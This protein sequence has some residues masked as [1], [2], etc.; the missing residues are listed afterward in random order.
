MNMGDAP[1]EHTCSAEI[2][3]QNLKILTVA[4]S[5][6]G[7]GIR[8]VCLALFYTRKMLLAGCNCMSNTGLLNKNIK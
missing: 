8:F 5:W 3:S 2:L 4:Y 7:T 1:C 6:R